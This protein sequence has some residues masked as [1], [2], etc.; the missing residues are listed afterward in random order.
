MQS[1]VRADRSRSVSAT[2]S[3]WPASAWRSGI[4]YALLGPNGA[5]K[6]TLIR[7]L[8]TLLKPDG[9]SAT[10]A[11]ID[12]VRDPTAVRNRIGLAGQFA[13]VDEYLTGREAVEMVG[14]LYNLSA[15]VARERAAEVL[16]RISLAADADRLVRTYS[17]GM[18]RRL[19]LAAS[20]VGRPDVL[21]LDEPTTGIDPRSRVDV[22]ALIRDLVSSGTT[23]L[24]T[25]QYLDE[26]DQLADRIGVIHEGRLISEG[27]GNELKD[28]LGGAVIQVE[29]PEAAQA[30]TRAALGADDGTDGT[31]TLPAPAGSRSLADAIRRL[32]A[33]G[34]DPT[35]IGLRRPTLDDVFIA[36]TGHDTAGPRRGRRR[37]RC[38]GRCRRPRGGQA[39]WIHAPRQETRMSGA[40]VSAAPAAGRARVSVG[41]A[42]K[43]TVVIV[44]RNLLRILR[45]PQLLV[46]ATVQ[47]VMF[48]ILF[49]YVFG[50]AVGRSVPAAAGGEYLNWLLPGVLLQMAAFGATQTAMGL[51]EDLNKGVIDR[52]R[53]LPM[54]RSAVLA[55]RTVADLIRNVFVMVLVLVLGYVLGFRPQTSFVPVVGGLLVAMMFAFA[56][57]WVMA[58]IGLSVKNSEAAQSA[59]MIP[60][61]PMVFASSVFVPLET[62]P[63]WLRVFAD[64]QPV[65]RTANAVRGLILG[66]GALAAGQTVAG[67]VAGA[68]L[69]ALG[70]VVVAAPLAVRLYRRAVS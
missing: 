36:L 25:T 3:P 15:Q 63:D 65:T 14:R 48:L 26:A 28:R 42:V 55:G 24:L 60:I 35:D 52:F 13:A 5:G 33:A 45:L 37:G 8:A 16:E 23:V 64:H 40:A 41:H 21:F 47:P 68:L 2:S 51:I 10:V 27:T 57:S 59:A 19:D 9:G 46:F 4:I 30:A 70:I 54:A 66:E 53:S 50:G 49:N 43:D 29:V 67:E 1:I 38:R 6:T 56:L 20:L 44:R 32:D 11:G 12:V 31:I 7:V 22:W 62:L 34:I 61:F 39:R 58:C 69:W 18:K 17:G